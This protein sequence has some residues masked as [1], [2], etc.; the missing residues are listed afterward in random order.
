MSAYIADQSWPDEAQRLR[1]LARA[2]DGYTQ[3]H[4]EGLGVTE[5]M[6]CLEVGAGCGSIAR[7]FLERV[8]PTGHVVATDLDVSLLAPLL[9]AGE[10]VS[11]RREDIAE[12]VPASPD[13]LG[14][15]RIHARLVLGHIARPELAL[16]HILSALRPGGIALIEDADFLWSDVGELPSYPERSARACFGVWRATVKLMQ[17]RG[18]DVHWGRRL[19]ASM[20]A[21]GFEQVRGEAVM[22]V[23]DAAL[24]AGM[25]MTIQRFAPA[26]VERGV[27]TQAELDACLSALADPQLTF[28]GSPTFSIWGTRPHAGL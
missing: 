21:V 7:W 4:L 10:R 27:V 28:T 24:Q 25:R 2:L 22:L 15:D 18:Y 5:G 1:A 3:R 12:Q 17:S 8:G 20:R 19:A 9:A 13:G 6:S 16:R 23:G 11:V 14:F 26:L